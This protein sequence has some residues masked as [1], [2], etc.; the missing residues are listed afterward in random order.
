M[1]QRVVEDKEERIRSHEEK[2]RSRELE[3]E[4]KLNDLRQR[5]TEVANQ[6]EF[7]NSNLHTIEVREAKSLEQVRIVLSSCPRPSPHDPGGSQSR[8]LRAWEEDLTAKDIELHSW[9]TL[10]YEMQEKLNDVELRESELE[11]RI[12]KHNAVED[13]FYNVKVAQITARHEKDV[14]ELEE[15]ITEQLTA[16]ANFQHELEKAKTEVSKKATQI[17]N[18]EV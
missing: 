1:E 10:L 8:K 12:V 9:E 4:R 6:S 18:L 5:E 3:L 15:V 7:Y 13:E 14:A 17:Q 16:V 11:E 2:L